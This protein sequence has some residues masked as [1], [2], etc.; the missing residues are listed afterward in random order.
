MGN[1]IEMLYNESKERESFNEKQKLLQMSEISIVLRSY[2]DLFSDFDPRTYDKR[3]LS[4]DFLA[5]IRRAA[6]EKRGGSVEVNFLIPTEQRKN[7]T[8]QMVRKR[9]HEYFNR[10]H[11]LIKKEIFSMRK[12]GAIISGFG[13]ILGIL[14]AFLIIPTDYTSTIGIIEITH[15]LALVLIE[16]ASWFTIWTGLDKIF[17]TW[18]HLEP[19]LEFYRKM[20]HSEINFTGY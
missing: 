1:P 13:F 16:P 11:D 17:T 15:K 4:D 8:E 18:K 20:S 2:D 9:L 7:E 6:K 10:H 12:S 3:G 14:G 5:E 19:D